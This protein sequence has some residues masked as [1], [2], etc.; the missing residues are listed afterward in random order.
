M[1]EQLMM[2][3]DEDKEP[4]GLVLS[5]EVGRF[6]RTDERWFTLPK[7]NMRFEGAEVIEV[8]EEFLKFYD[9]LDSKGKNPPT[10]DQ[11]QAY[12]IEDEEE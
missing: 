1:A 4:L 2:M 11:T 12:E 3:F 10:Y 5:T 6:V 7:S 9:K 8:E